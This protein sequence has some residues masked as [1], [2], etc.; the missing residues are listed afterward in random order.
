MDT[1]TA[2]ITIGSVVIAK[3]C[4][5]LGLWLRLRWRA[6][7]EQSRHDYLLGV[8]RAVAGCG[9]VELDDQHRDGHRLRVKISRAP[10]HGEDKAA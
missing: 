10:E 9:R 2:V 7:R 5:L 4:A 3:G 6:R 1:T 8:A